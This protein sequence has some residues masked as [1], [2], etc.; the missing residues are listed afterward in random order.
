M[1]IGIQMGLTEPHPFAEIAG[2]RTPLPER[3]HSKRCV[4]DL[5]GHLFDDIEECARHGKR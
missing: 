2:R 4:S 3:R 5:P 1:L